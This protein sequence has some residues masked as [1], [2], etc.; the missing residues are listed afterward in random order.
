MTRPSI[1]LI[2]VLGGAISLQAQETTKCDLAILRE[3]NANLNNLDE[4]QITQF[5][6]TFD[7][8]CDINVEYSEFSN[9][10]LFQVLDKHTAQLLT[11]LLKQGEVLRMDV[12]LNELSSPV[13]DSFDI[14]ELISKVRK[15]Q[16]NK[17]LQEDV[18]KVLNEAKGK[19]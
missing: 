13:N 3:T 1:I 10:L 16:V 7:T 2:L 15:A 4:K 19:L 14:E 12:I 18:I 17:R 5:L 9:E 11:V 8:S 6:F